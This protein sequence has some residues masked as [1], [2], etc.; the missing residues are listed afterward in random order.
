LFDFVLYTIIFYRLIDDLD[1]ERLVGERD[2]S[3]IQMVT[4]ALTGRAL[5]YFHNGV[6]DV[7]SNGD[8]MEKPQHGVKGRC[9]VG[10]LYWSKYDDDS[11]WHKQEMGS[12]LRTPKV[13]VWLICLNR[14]YAIMFST[15]V[16]LLNNWIYENYFQLH[17]YTGLRKQEEPCI[18]SIDTRQQYPTSAYGNF[19]DD[20]DQR[21]PDIIPLLQ[22]RLI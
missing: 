7:D 19:F 4:L 11:F 8:L 18:L 3:S 12:M 21:T 20:D 6:I 13:P 15:N 22:S 1:H 10:F 16:N 2:E 17:I 9:S 14:R 5:H